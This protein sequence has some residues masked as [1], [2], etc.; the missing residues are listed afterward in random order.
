MHHLTDMEHL[1][2]GISL[3]SVGHEQ[4]LVV[5]K[6]EGHASFEALLA[7]IQHDVAR[8]IYRVGISKEVPKKKEAVPVGKKVGRNVPCPCGS[9][10]KYKHCCGK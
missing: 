4:P 5:Y 7:S 10:K 9:G 2:Q 3:R 8:S 1:R 6:R